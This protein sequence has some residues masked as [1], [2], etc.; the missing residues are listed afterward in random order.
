M[1][2]LQI[3]TKVAAWTWVGWDAGMLEEVSKG[4]EVVRSE[5]VADSVVYVEA[6]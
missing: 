6:L 1:G 3:D 2:Q 5:E 4:D